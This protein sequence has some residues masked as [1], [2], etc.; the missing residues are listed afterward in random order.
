M[1]EII[2]H[3]FVPVIGS[4][5]MFAF[6]L[7]NDRLSKRKRNFFMLT[8]MFY[9][10]SIFFRNADL[11]TSEYDTITIRRAFYSA[12][13]YFTRTMV[14]YSLIG[15]DFDLKQKKYKIY[16]SILIIPILITLFSAFSVFYTD[17]VYSFQSPNN[18]HSGPY[19]WLNYAPLVLYFF[20]VLAIAVRDFVKREYRHGTMILG[21]LFLMASAM[22]FEYFSFH[23]LLS[24]SA[25]ALALM[26]YLFFFQDD[27]YINEQQILK[28]KALTDALTGCFNRAGYDE[29]VN[30]Y[31]KEKNL[32]VAMIVMDIDKFKLVNDN[33]GHDVGDIILKNVSKLLTVTFRSSDYIIRYGGDEFVVV[34]IGI[35]EEMTPVVVNKI[36][37]INV[38]LE[39][40]ISDIPKTSVSAGLAFS[41]NGF[42]PELFK[43]ADEAM[44]ERKTT[45]RRGCTVYREEEFKKTETN[46]S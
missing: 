27:E 43:H 28:Q 10:L 17:K 24:E 40:P 39:N 23:E 37:S 16:Y 30:H 21:T 2:A 31:S 9:L 46:S 19:A 3:N 14:V 33:Y 22:L 12:C 13:G 38:Q 32:E 15:T 1:K 18:F 25:V 29:I 6:V 41:K 5:M 35:T 26:L 44:Y 8:I 45:T 36:E 42:T 11:I 20:V 34:I 7:K 4:L